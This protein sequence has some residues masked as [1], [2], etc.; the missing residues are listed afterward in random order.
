MDRHSVGRC[1]PAEAASGAEIKCLVFLADGQ[2]LL[3]VLRL[4]DR[5]S[6]PLLARHLG[7][8]KSRL[9]LAPNSMV[10]GWAKLAVRRL[11]PGPPGEW[12]AT[13]AEPSLIYL[14]SQRA[15]KL[16]DGLVT[17]GWVVGE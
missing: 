10:F 11:D 4:E 9:K 13:S 7:L 14:F 6:Q 2:P 12:A 17:G 3:V 15:N 16:R 5:V 1:A 8:P